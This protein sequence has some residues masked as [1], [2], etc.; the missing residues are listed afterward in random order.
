MSAGTGSSKHWTCG[1]GQR[2]IGAFGDLCGTSRYCLSAATFTPI[3]T[4]PHQ[5]GRDFQAAIGGYTKVSLRG[6]DDKWSC[7]PLSYQSLMSVVTDTPIMKMG[8]CLHSHANGYRKRGLD[9]RVRRPLWNLQICLSAASFTPILTFPHQG[10]RD[11]RHA[12]P[13]IEYGT[14]SNLPSSRGKGFP[15]SYRGLYKG[16]STGE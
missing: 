12:H 6:N 13:R 10:G 16:P 11:F 3:L 14:G 4:F 9:S 1:S 2:W 15:G 8:S 7:R 5:G